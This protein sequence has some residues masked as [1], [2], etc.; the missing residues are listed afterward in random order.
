M[1]NVFNYSKEEFF[2]NSFPFY[3]KKISYGADSHI[4]MHTHDFLEI[5]YIYNGNGLHII[6][7]KE[8][9]VEK[10]EIFI[11]NTEMAHSFYPID[12]ENSSNL[13]IFNCLFLPEF[14]KGID[15]ESGLFKDIINMFLYKSIYYDEIIHEA[16]VKLTG[17]DIH[18][19]NSLYENMLSEF[20]VKALGYEEILKISLCELLIKI[21]RVY[22]AKEISYAKFKKQE[23]ILEVVNYL[24]DNYYANINIEKISKMSLLSKSH[25]SKLF[26]ASVGMSVFEYLQKLRIEKACELLVQNE[27]SIVN[28]AETVG[29]CDYR[30]FNK[31]FKKVTGKTASTYKKQFI[32]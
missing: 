28:I 25:F 32:I 1:N 15:F 16:D 24:K 12:K 11:I 6:N 3:I 9:L 7:G 19:F 22:V 21:Y 30:Y 20:T 4:V 18:D 8:H 29:Y 14:I 31:I 2:L 23:L 17:N 13:M 27:K 5:A 26:K 10:G